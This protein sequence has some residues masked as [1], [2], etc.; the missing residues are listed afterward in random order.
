MSSPRLCDYL[1]MQG[2]HRRSVRR[3]IPIAAVG[4]IVASCSP[5]KSVARSWIESVYTNSDI[6]WA[7]RN[8]GESQ[9]GLDWYPEIGFSLQELRDAWSELCG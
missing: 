4:M 1:Q 9:A 6:D 7:C 8:L 5:G 3:L 2:P